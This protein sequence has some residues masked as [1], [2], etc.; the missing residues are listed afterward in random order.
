MSLLCGKPLMR[1][2]ASSRPA[3]AKPL[4]PSRLVKTGAVSP[5]RV[6]P[7]QIAC[8][9]ARAAPLRALLGSI[10]VDLDADPQLA[11]RFACCRAP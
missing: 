2:L 11:A 6:R 1:G 9:H 5:I 4:L 7:S 3:V 8:R 10:D